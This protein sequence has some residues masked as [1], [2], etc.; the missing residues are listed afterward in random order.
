M[1]FAVMGSQGSGKTTVLEEMRKRGY[2][3]IERKTS[4]S[5][6]QE[7]GF[8][9]SEVNNNRELTVRFQEEILRR[10][11]Q[12]E[13]FHYENSSDIVFTERTFVDLFTYALVALGKDNEYSSWLDDYYQRCK[14]AQARYSG[15]FY[16]Q[17][18]LFPVEN[19]GVRAI[20]QHYSKMVD[21]VMSYTAAD[22]TTTCPVFNVSTRDLQ[23]RAEYIE[24]KSLEI[25]TTLDGVY[26]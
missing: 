12:D 4:R 9:L 14:A 19:D 15:I 6:L 11:I 21:T 13:F 10:K 17:G 18:G 8:T 16:L 3:L 7:W 26:R 22:M 23:E 20:N 5:I 1:I 2:R 24:K 25:V